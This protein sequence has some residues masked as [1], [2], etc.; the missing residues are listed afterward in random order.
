M[1]YV[2]LNTKNLIYLPRIG[3]GQMIVWPSDFPVWWGPWP[4]GPL[5]W[6]RHWLLLCALLYF[7]LEMLYV[8]LIKR[9]ERFL[10]LD[11]FFTWID[12]LCLD[13]F[14]NVWLEF[15]ILILV[16]VLAYVFSCVCMWFLNDL[17]VITF[18]FFEF[19]FYV[20]YKFYWNHHVV[21]YFL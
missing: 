9:M 8:F 6:V 19:F 13:N 18:Y 12:H 4:L 7:F 16:Y 1:Y 14:C 20:S 2:Y 15:N 11:L 3:G 21:R 17:C 10:F 5:P